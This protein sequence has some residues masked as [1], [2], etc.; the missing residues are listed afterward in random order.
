MMITSM[1]KKLLLFSLPPFFAVV[2]FVLFVV[3]LNKDS[4]K[5]ALQV[6]ASPKSAVFLNDKLIGETPLCKCEGQDM[7]ATGSYA[8]RLVPKEGDFPPY[9]EHIKI[10]SS[11][12]TVVD[13][14]F[15]NA[16]LGEGKVIT[17]DALSSSTAVELSILSFPEDITVYADNNEIGKTPLKITTLTASDHELRLVKDGYREKKIRIKLVAGYRVTLVATLGILLNLESGNTTATPS[18]SVQQ[19][20]SVSAIPTVV[21]VI[22]LNTPTGFLRVRDSGSLSGKEIA[23]VKPGETYDLVEEKV[24]WFSIKLPNGKIGWVSSSYA[25]KQ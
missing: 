24:G 12:L 13:R 2:A 10:G 9:E 16:G 14:I 18:A 21:K 4:G 23:Q 7:L 17:L 20:A 15:G 5:G 25:K 6:T 8:V 1:G 3:Y 19:V 22:I 11:V